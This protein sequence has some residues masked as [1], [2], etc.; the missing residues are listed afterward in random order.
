MGQKEMNREL[1]TFST[2][3]NNNRVYKNMSCDYSSASKETNS[4]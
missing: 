2:K 1:K 3:F 4:L